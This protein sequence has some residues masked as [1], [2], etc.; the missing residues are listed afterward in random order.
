M[1]AQQTLVAKTKKQAERER[2]ISEQERDL[3]L[4]DDH[5]EDRKI[6]REG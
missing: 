1:V 5:P 2:L 3:G 4:Q 6:L